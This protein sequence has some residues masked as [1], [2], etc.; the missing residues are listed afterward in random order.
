MDYDI[1]LPNK[2]YRYIN[3]TSFQNDKLR[4]HLTKEDNLG[5]NIK[6]DED[7]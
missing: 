6:L 4:I 1:L 5:S 7:S 2:D 3:S